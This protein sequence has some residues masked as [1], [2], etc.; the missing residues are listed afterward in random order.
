MD[1]FARTAM[2]EA[3][4]A[5]A[6]N[7]YAGDPWQLDRVD[8]ITAAAVDACNT[9]RPLDGMD[10]I[11]YQ[12]NHVLGTAAAAMRQAAKD[13]S[14]NDF[15]RCFSDLVP[16][17]IG[18]P[19]RWLE[20]KVGSRMMFS[21]ANSNVYDENYEWDVEQTAFYIDGKY[22]SVD[23]LARALAEGV[24]TPELAAEFEMDDFDDIAVN[25]EVLRDR[26]TVWARGRDSFES[27]IQEKVE[28]ED[29]PL[30]RTRF[31]RMTKDGP[32]YT[33]ERMTSGKTFEGSVLG[34]DEAYVAPHDYATEDFCLAADLRKGAFKD[35]GAPG[36]DKADPE[37]VANRNMPLIKRLAKHIKML[38]NAYD[39][40]L[41]VEAVLDGEI[42]DGLLMAIHQEVSS[43]NITE[44]SYNAVCTE[45]ARRV[46][47]IVKHKGVLATI[48]DR[49]G[50][51]WDDW[52]K[53]E[54]RD[55]V[56]SKKLRDLI[57][58]ETEAGRIFASRGAIVLA[59]IGGMHPGHAAKLGDALADRS[60]KLKRILDQGK[61]STEAEILIVDGVMPLFNEGI[62]KIRIGIVGPVRAGDVYL[63]LMEEHIH[64]YVIVGCDN[65]AK[66]V[67]AVLGAEYY[68]IPVSDDPRGK[69]W[70]GG[71]VCASSSHAMVVMPEKFRSVKLQ[72]LK[73]MD[74]VGWFV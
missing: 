51:S 62:P 30:I 55:P 58:E 71:Q 26:L 53:D 60:K 72:Q 24:S 69:K 40:R 12:A 6:M 39:D 10:D 27:L 47:G 36:F 42:I 70:A 28:V 73:A 20:D 32:V 29:A 52:G 8:D 5:I 37:M 48:K 33:G 61:F 56:S 22:W 54:E 35:T 14:E 64:R 16:D 18:D 4:A 63:K 57:I 9:Y 15:V 59:K 66:N 7:T 67:A 74:V 11:F 44:S 45:F 50:V 38:T 49:L 19:A 68:A 46:S 41:P 17:G 2:V 23:H 21:P 25:T 65:N 31:G 34:H 1:S 13:D 43:L 3:A